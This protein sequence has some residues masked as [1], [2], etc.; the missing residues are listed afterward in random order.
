LIHGKIANKNLK[1]LKL[2][3]CIYIFSKFNLC[4]LKGLF[5]YIKR[6]ISED[7]DDR[8]K[9]LRKAAER[10]WMM[11]MPLLLVFGDDDKLK[12]LHY[13]YCAVTVEESINLEMIDS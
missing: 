4:L 9:Q 12:I 6:P 10:K 3:I 1:S 2:Y 11:K 7:I 13:A 8:K 5:P